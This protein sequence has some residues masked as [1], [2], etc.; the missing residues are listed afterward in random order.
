MGVQ[1]GRYTDVYTSVYLYV[2]TY[3]R[4]RATSNIH[5]EVTYTM[6]ACK[7]YIRTVLPACGGM[8][9]SMNETTND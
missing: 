7:T 5:N 8:V 6:P 1:I 2:S 9:E 3:V 4:T